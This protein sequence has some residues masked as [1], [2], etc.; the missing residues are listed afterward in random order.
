MSLV[1]WSVSNRLRLEEGRRIA[2]ALTKPVMPSILVH[3]RPDESVHCNF[4]YK[5]KHKA[6]YNVG[7]GETNL[8]QYKKIFSDQ[9]RQAF[10]ET[11]PPA[12][13]PNKQQSDDW[14]AL[15][16]NCCG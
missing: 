8:I 10:T 1:I 3:I 5:L 13:R 15:R 11:R 7:A 12:N 6:K 2:D 4:K 14:A 9:I 16:M